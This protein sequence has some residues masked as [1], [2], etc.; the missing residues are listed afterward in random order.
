MVV[1]G[2][3]LAGDNWTDLRTNHQ[4]ATQGGPS[5][6]KNTVKREVKNRQLIRT[7]D[8]TRKTLKLKKTSG[9]AGMEAHNQTHLI[10]WWK[11]TNHAVWEIE[12]PKVTGKGC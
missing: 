2:F 4:I 1:P 8:Q 7:G 10:L 12:G 9:E 6:R 5:D 3:H 11:K